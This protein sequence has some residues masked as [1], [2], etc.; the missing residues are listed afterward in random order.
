MV[1]KFTLQ[2]KKQLSDARAARQ[3]R[4]K[5]QKLDVVSQSNEEENSS[6][7]QHDCDPGDEPDNQPWY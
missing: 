6:A 4:V 7:A 2:Q 5:R 1:S 3:P